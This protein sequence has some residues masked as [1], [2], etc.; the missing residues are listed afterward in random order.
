M[1][2]IGKG[3]FTPGQVY[4]A[5]SRCRRLEGIVLK[6]KITE[7]HIWSDWQVSRFVINFQHQQAAKNLSDEEKI[8]LLK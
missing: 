2:D 6:E 5:L 4:V 1:I 7:K 3:S 8:N